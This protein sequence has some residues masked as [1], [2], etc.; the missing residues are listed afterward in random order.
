MDIL[1]TEVNKSKEYLTKLPEGGVL[2]TIS[3]AIPNTWYGPFIG[4]QIVVV[5]HD[6][7]SS[8]FI[9]YPGNFM[10]YKFDL[11]WDKKVRAIES[12]MPP[13][14]DMVDAYLQNDGFYY[15]AVLGEYF[16][17]EQEHLG[18]I[19]KY[20]E[21]TWKYILTDANTYREAV[22]ILK[23]PDG[24]KDSRR[25]MLTQ[26]YFISGIMLAV[27]LVLIAYYIMYV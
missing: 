7:M 15:R 24:V 20:S 17:D 18:S 4:E 8:M 23:D 3:K 11:V 12:D 9:M 22:E 26:I 27:V 25:R 2:A 21:G 16:E 19:A 5:P 10:I 14:H 6:R 1:T 13:Y